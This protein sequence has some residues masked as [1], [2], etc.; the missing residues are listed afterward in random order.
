MVL[1]DGSAIPGAKFYTFNGNAAR[2]KGHHKLKL[3]Y[4]ED[5]VA[6]CGVAGNGDD[7]HTVGSLVL[8]QRD[9]DGNWF[10]CG[11]AGSG[12]TRDGGELDRDVIKALCDEHDAPFMQD[13][14]DPPR[15]DRLNLDTGFV[16]EIEYKSRQPGTH[17][18]KF[19][20]ITRVR[21]DKT[22]DE[23]YSEVC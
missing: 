1:V 15:A 7:R 17:K 10:D 11:K 12:L 16:V 20:V 21:Y 19:P 22:K 18:F 6:F 5:C 4:T 13:D 9:K 3:N 14:D 23:C 2:P 8:K